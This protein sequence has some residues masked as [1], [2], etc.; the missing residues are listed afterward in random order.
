MLR[1]RPAEAD[2][3]SDDAHGTNRSQGSQDQQAWQAQQ[4]PPSQA[5][6][7][8]RQEGMGVKAHNQP[9]REGKGVSG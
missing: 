8:H 7:C 2:R 5:A 3:Q 6:G 9:G 4:R 1:R